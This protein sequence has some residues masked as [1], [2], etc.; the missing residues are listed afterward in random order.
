[1]SKGV[2]LGPDQGQCGG[3]GGNGGLRD[4][5]GR[6]DRTPKPA[7][8]SFLSSYRKRGWLEL[9]PPPRGLKVLAS[10]MPA[11]AGEEYY[12]VEW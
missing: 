5:M 7:E 1:M 2:S 3:R 4:R 11:K 6:Q 10:W 12:G 9:F 8:V